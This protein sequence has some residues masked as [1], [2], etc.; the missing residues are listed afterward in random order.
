MRRVQVGAFA[1]ALL[2]ALI[3]ASC[4]R[5]AVPLTG[6]VADAYTGA[7]VVATLIIGDTQVTTDANGSYQ[8]NRWSARDVI[9][10]VA[11]G[12]EPAEIDLSALPNLQR[13]EPPAVRLDP[14]RM[15]PNTLSGTITDLYTG[16][17]VAGA[18][19]QV[20]ETISDTT[21][22]TGRYMLSGVP[23]TF[24]VTVAAVGYAPLVRDLSRTTSFD[25]AIR[26]DTL[27]GTVTDRYTGQPIAGALVSLGDF[28]STTD[29]KGQYLLQG[30]PEK[31]T[32]TISAK[33]YASLDQPI[34][35][36][37]TLD[38]ALRPDTLS[39]ILLDAQSKRPIRNATIIA[40]LNLQSS[41][42][43]M[44]RIDNSSDGSFTL[45][46][47][48]E[49]GYL[50]VLAP[51]YRKAVVELRPGSAPMTIELEPF[52]AKALY[53]TAA[54]AARWDRLMQY[55]DVI[56]A[57]ELN[58]IVIDIKSDLRNDLG[59]VYYDSQVPIVRE[60]G[61]FKPYM[62][63]RKI[64]DEAKRRGIYT[65]ARVHIFSHD[66]VLAEAKPEWAA[67]DRTTGGIFYDYPAPGIRYAWLDPWNENV[68]DYNIQLSVEAALLGFD[69]IQYDYIR[70]PS[71]EFSPTDKDRLLLSR[72]G[73]TEERWANITEVLRR[74]HRAINGAGAFFSVDV[75]GYTSFRP[76]QTLGQN[77]SMMAEYTDYI[78]PMIYPSHFSP[79]E[80]G[81]DNPAKYPYEV[82]QKA[83]AA[84][85]RQV[86][87]KRALLRPWLQDFT[88]IWVPK[89]QI[90]EYTPA[91]V[92]AQIRAVE[93][94]DA[95]AGW[96]LYDSTNVYHVEAL[97]PAE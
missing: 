78:S 4:G 67:K 7:P 68:W 96:I 42:V 88:L 41:D 84:A 5:P 12:Y 59:L 8:I 43:A 83:M 60:L 35:R 24:R 71:L 77:L 19:V 70:F 37:T 32:I 40:T 13:P 55:F 14:L 6:T 75:F 56:D 61:T 25:A 36:I 10:V 34:E 16:K 90:V 18:L 72:E 49:R 47:I 20:S 51:G 91:E 97:K 11:N 94:F 29:S 63:L 79:G 3:A 50:Q 85:L 22:A 26:P 62:D 86:E 2:L 46:G 21:D 64:L 9:K 76:S 81:F 52:Y 48:P 1:S 15:R 93:E 89:D 66:N 65:I 54:T 31:G 23:E 27:R 87:G 74:S 82:I 38:A 30:V 45:E 57:T 92:R 44:T 28:R 69:E 33:G 39:G 53:V 80:F 17:P 58:A 95:G 73:T